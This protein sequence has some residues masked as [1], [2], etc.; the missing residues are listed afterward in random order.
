MSSLSIPPIQIPS[1]P[2]HRIRIYTPP[3]I[4]IPPIKIPTTSTQKITTPSYFGAIFF[5]FRICLMKLDVASSYFESP[6]KCNYL[7]LIFDIQSITK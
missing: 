7:S 1:I 3:P 5:C 6:V 2:P 4:P